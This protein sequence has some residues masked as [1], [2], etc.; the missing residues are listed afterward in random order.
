VLDAPQTFVRCSVCN[1]GDARK[2]FTVMAPE[3]K[4]PAFA[5]LTRRRFLQITAA[6]FGAAATASQFGC[7]ADKVASEKGIR[8]VATTCDVCFWKCGLIATVRDGRLWKLE[9]NPLDP[10]SRGRLCP[11]GTA[12]IGMVEDPYRLRAP[13]IRTGKRGE[14][15]WRVATWD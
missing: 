6:S 13:L 4:S 3:A 15:Q 2:T 12:G 10:L 5:P 11:R 8:T 9:G 14:E 7:A 1:G